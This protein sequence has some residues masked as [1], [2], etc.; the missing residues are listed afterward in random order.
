MSHR[1]LAVLLLASAALTAAPA[2]GP[3]IATMDDLRFTPPKGKGSA[4]LVDGKV[5]K[6]VKFH[7]DK[8]A[9]GAFFTSPIRGTPDWDKAAGFSFL[10]KGDGTDQ[11]PGLELIYDNDYAVR[12]DLAFPVK[13]GGWM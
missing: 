5:G 6:A 10:V 1:L 3:V 13:G 8:D 12:Y 4:E 7:F 9:R 11:F 2:D